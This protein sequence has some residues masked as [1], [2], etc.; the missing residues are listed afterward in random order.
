ML[1]SMKSSNEHLFCDLERFASRTALKTEAGDVTYGELLAV[2]RT[3]TQP[4]ESRKLVMILCTNSVASIAAYVCCL[5]MGVVP[6]MVSNGIDRALLQRL[7]SVYR[8]NAV[9][10]PEGG[11][12]G[13]SLAAANG[14]R[15]YATE[16]ADSIKLSPELALLLTTS[17]STGSPKLVRLTYA[18]LMANTASIIEYL[19]IVPTDVAITTLP[20][21]YT[22]GLSIINTHLCAGASILVTEKTFLERDIWDV[23][24]QYGVTNFGAI[25]YTFA[26]LCNAGGRQA[27]SRVAAAIRRVSALGGQEL[28]R[29]VWRYGGDGKN[30]LSPR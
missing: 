5:R 24:R 20:M 13:R 10:A 25:P 7:F 12:Q 14:Y 28:Y 27:G 29:H 26:A 19:G 23:F 16:Y 30:G 4:L 11:W 15:L 21:N 6:I 2:G 8:P 17:G 18:N 1:R 22:Y 9:L 3:L